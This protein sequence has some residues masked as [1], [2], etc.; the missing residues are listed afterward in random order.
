MDYIGRFQFSNYY[1]EM[2]TAIDYPNYPIFCY[3]WA[4]A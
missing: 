2:V 4:E 1:L 3:S